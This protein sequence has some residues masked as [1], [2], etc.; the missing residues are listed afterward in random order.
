[1]ALDE[2]DRQAALQI[3]EPHM[4]DA[5]LAKRFDGRFIRNLARSGPEKSIQTKAESDLFKLVKLP[6]E[7]GNH[8]YQYR[9]TAIS[10]DGK[11]LAAAEYVPLGHGGA[12][13]EKRVAVS[14]THLTLPTTPYV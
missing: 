13:K 8:R 11:L 12:F 2:G 4:R 9:C 10:N 14:Y 6:T 1:M 5:E 7:F 3:I